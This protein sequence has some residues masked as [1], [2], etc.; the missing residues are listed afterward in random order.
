MY[1]AHP[2]FFRHSLVIFFGH[3]VVLLEHVQHLSEAWKG[4]AVKCII[5]QHI[6]FLK[7]N[8]AY[9]TILSSDT[10]VMNI[11]AMTCVPTAI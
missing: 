4:I 5:H 10:D 7:K 3:S 2:Q 1:K 11:H 9:K 8:I 6:H